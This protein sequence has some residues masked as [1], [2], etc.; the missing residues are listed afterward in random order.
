MRSLKRDDSPILRGFQIY[1]NFIRP[2]QALNGSTP[3]E[4][5]GIKIEGQDK[6]LTLIRNAQSKADARKR[7]S[8]FADLEE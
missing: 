1:H 2:H 5:A 4:M 7:S 3:A 8:D 6:W